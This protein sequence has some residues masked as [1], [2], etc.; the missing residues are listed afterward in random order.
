MV[1]LVGLLIV[2]LATRHGSSRTAAPTAAK[3]SHIADGASPGPTAAPSPTSDL[4]RA[5]DAHGVSFIYPSR[6]HRAAPTAGL[7]LV[8]E[9][10]SWIE[11]LGGPPS[12]RLAV[13]AYQRRDP[14]T[15]VGRAGIARRV[16]RRV[17]ALLGSP[18]PFRVSP[19]TTPAPE[20]VYS[21]PGGADAPATTVSG[22]VVF[23]ARTRYVVGCQV[24]Y[25]ATTDTCAA[26]FATFHLTGGGLSGA[27]PA[28]RSVVAAVYAAWRSGH[29]SD[30]R[31]LM[32]SQALA[33]LTDSP[34]TEG[35]RP[36]SSCVPSQAPVGHGLGT[37][38][39]LIPNGDRAAKLLMLRPVRGHWKVTSVGEC[40]GSIA[41]FRCAFVG[42][43]R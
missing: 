5:F 43:V 33:A 22:Y 19:T 6:W 18:P 17:A 14:G 40:T 11:V 13:A 1:V 12:T 32:M 27:T 10:P 8:P 26:I 31:S 39:C 38:Q 25:S 34:W 21:I 30:A 36:P 24:V 15:A 41:S 37:F 20:F 23:S 42:A 3:P 16:G 35:T 2:G 7:R 28:V 4:P 29:P 9:E